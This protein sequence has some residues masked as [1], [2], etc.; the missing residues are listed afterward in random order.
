[1]IKPPIVDL[2]FNL[3]LLIWVIDGI[4]KGY[5]TW[6]GNAQ[7]FLEWFP[8]NIIKKT[9]QKNF[10]LSEDELL[11]RYTSVGSRMI[12]IYGLI[13]FLGGIFSMVLVVMLIKHSLLAVIGAGL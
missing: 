4:I 11:R 8:V 12:R 7:A 3:I 1:M 10:N 2:I 13:L 9:I 5:K 6:R